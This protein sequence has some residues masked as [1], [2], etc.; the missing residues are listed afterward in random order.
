[1]REEEEAN[2]RRLDTVSEEEIEAV[3]EWHRMQQESNVVRPKRP[4]ANG[5]CRTRQD[6]SEAP[7][8][9]RRS[10]DC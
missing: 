6:R 10:N 2:A 4:A 9:C 7:S 5:F 1:M 8:C 3:L